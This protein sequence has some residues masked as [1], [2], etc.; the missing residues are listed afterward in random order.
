M[1]HLLENKT[2]CHVT[3][4]HPWNDIRIFK[5]EAISTAKHAK[6]TY[7]V[8][9]NAPNE[10]IENVYITNV[11]FPESFSRIKRMFFL[12]K[13]VIKKAL[14]LNADIY[15][16]HDPELLSAV[17]KIRKKG[18][19]VI[20]DS[21]EDLPKSL[22][23]KSWLKFDWL[24]KV[25]SKLYN[26]YEKRICKKCDGVISVLPEITNQFENKHLET[27]YN[28]PL[29]NDYGLKTSSSE[30]FILI[31]N[32]G[33]TRIR[34]IKEICE[35]MNHLENSFELKLL[36]K[37]E[38]EAFRIECM[39]TVKRP[40]GINYLGLVDYETCQRELQAA[41]VGLV[42]FHKVP[43][44]EI[45]LPNKS[46]EYVINELPVI[47]SDIAYWKKEFDSFAAFA[48]PKDPKEIAKRIQNVRSD[49]DSFKARTKTYRQ[50]VIAEKNWN[51][52][53][54]KLISFYNEVLQD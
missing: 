21:H 39:N 15:H 20:Y 10:C 25:I 54:R 50:K 46:F 41:D 40:D 9:T 16:L 24:R 51:T 2:V 27:I 42:M 52:E 23:S 38:S 17:R 18:K 5:K 37:W 30:K 12:K 49:Y 29:L 35:A 19:R 48:D 11:I 3:S 36:G 47:M 22:L 44:H 6:K 53:E 1:E 7:L 45:S 34:G 8:A 43:N 4:V 14:S 26:H 13:R 32:G 33:L 28:Y 31:Y